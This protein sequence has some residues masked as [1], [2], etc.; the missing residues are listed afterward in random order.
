[1]GDFYRLFFDSSEIYSVASKGNYVYQEWPPEVNLP[2]SRP[3]IAGAVLPGMEERDDQTEEEA[4]PKKFDL[5]SSPLSNRPLMFW[6]TESVQPRP[7]EKM[8]EIKKEVIETWKYL[9]ARQKFAV[10]RAVQIG[11]ALIK[12]QEKEDLDF[13]PALEQ[14]AKKLGVKPI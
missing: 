4:K 5:W 10:P 2:A 3:L 8:E 9:Q 12:E 7:P 1:E 13:L 6:K 14:E 11:K